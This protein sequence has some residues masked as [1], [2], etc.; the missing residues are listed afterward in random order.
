MDILLTTM[1]GLED[2]VL[3]ELENDFGLRGKKLR[4]GRVVVKGDPEDVVRLSYSGRTFERVMVLLAVEEGVEKLDDVYRA[5]F[6][7]PLGEYFCPDLTFACRSDRMGEHPFT[8]LDVERT[9]GQAVVDHFM[10]ATG[11]RIKANLE[12][13]D[14]IVRADLDG[15]VLYI[16]LD[17]TGYNAMHKRGYRVYDHPASLNTTLASALIRVGKWSEEKKL[18]D[19]FAGGGTIPIEA[20]LYAR[21]VPWFRYRSFLFERSGIIDAE[22]VRNVKE[23]LLSEVR[24][25]RIRA[26]GVEKYGKHVAGARKNAESAG[27][28]DTVTFKVGDASKI[29]VDADIIVTN[30]PYGQRIARPKV[31]S[32]LYYKFAESA[33]ERNIPKITTVTS[34]WKW[35]EDA[36][37]QAGYKIK[38]NFFVLYGKLHTRVIVAVLG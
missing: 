16:A 15:D 29:D 8:S 34:R 37:Q 27:V 21:K 28:E 18:L 11:K 5:V 31:V 2:V 32:E 35:M 12:D 30:P 9:A 13:P 25:T 23:E 22:V 7:A 26:T 36:L 6:S 14:V 3:N 1:V 38:K 20:A 17:A 10:N 4:N 24:D 19:P 33:A